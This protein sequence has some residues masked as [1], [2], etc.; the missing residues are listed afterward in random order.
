MLLY[1]LAITCED[2][3][4]ID[5]F[6]RIHRPEEFI[7]FTHRNVVAGTVVNSGYFGR[8]GFIGY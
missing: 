2:I 8:A 4:F 3:H 1:P 6:L 5:P 7:Q